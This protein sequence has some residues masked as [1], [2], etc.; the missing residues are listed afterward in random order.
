MI[1]ITWDELPSMAFNMVDS[2]VIA[3]PRGKKIEKDIVFD[4]FD[5]IIQGK[6][7]IKTKGFEKEIVDKE[8]YPILLNNTVVANRDNYADLVF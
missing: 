8:I 6:A 7:E 3:Y 2:R 5:D 4:W 1:G